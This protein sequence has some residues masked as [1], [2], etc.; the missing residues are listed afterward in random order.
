MELSNEQQVLLKELEENI[1]KRNAA[2]DEAHVVAFNRAKFPYVDKSRPYYS[3]EEKQVF[4]NL[5]KTNNQLEASIEKLIAESLLCA[6]QDVELCE[7]FKANGWDL[8]KTIKDEVYQRVG[9]DWWEFVKCGLWINRQIAAC[10]IPKETI[11]NEL[12]NQWEALKQFPEENLD[13]LTQLSQQISEL[14][15][16]IEKEQKAF[17]ADWEL[18]TGKSIEELLEERVK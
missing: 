17:I 11:Y 10:Q 2:W 7:R 5:E 16:Q 6:I 14:A 18:I 8:Q 3:F 12:I 13:R 1:I 15:E 9:V 4:V